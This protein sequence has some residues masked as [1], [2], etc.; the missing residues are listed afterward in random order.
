MNRTDYDAVIFDVDGTILDTAEGI[1][2]SVRYMIN[3][4]N[5]PQIEERTL[6]SF[7]GPRIQDSLV[8]VYGLQGE[9]CRRAAGVFRDRYKQGDVLKAKPYQGL[10]ET[11][12][13]LSATGYRLSVA[14]NKRQDFTDALLEKNGLQKYFEA[15]NGTDMEG[16]FTKKDLIERCVAEMKTEPGR[17]VLIGDSSYDAEAAEEVGV[18]FIAALYGYDFRTEQDVE[19]WKHIGVIRDIRDLIKLQ[20]EGK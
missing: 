7:V 20:E 4:L 17:T 12:G 6:N 2:A 13:I 16:R 1:L 9:E 11:L 3:T 19:R 18:S 8:R 14:T 5:F 10:E 15:V